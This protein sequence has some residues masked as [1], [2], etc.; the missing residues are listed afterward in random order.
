MT[1]IIC[2]QGHNRQRMDIAF[3]DEVLKF[4]EEYKLRKGTEAKTALIAGVLTYIK[5]NHPHW[6]IISSVK[7]SGKTFWEEVSDETAK[8]RIKYILNR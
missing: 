3:R 8:N 5:E 1:D 6:R 4:Q 2:G 7:I